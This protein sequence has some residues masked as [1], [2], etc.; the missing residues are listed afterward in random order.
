MLTSPTSSSQEEPQVLDQTLTNRFRN[1]NIIQV[2]NSSPIISLTNVLFYR[3][4]N[5]KDLS[6]NSNP[7]KILVKYDL[8]EMT[9]HPFNM[10][11][12]TLFEM[13]DFFKSG[14]KN[15]RY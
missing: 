13:N 12:S 7:F 4:V 6:D 10:I 11:F 3:L 14:E 9:N 15:V 2:S 1:Q 5:P 8:V